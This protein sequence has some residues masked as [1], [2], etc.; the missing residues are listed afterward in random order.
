MTESSRIFRVPG[1]EITESSRIPRVLGAELAEYSRVPWGPGAEMTESSRAPRVLKAEMTESSRVTR[2]PEAQMTGTY[3]FW[4]SDD[5]WSFVSH[6]K[7]SDVSWEQNDDA[8]SHRLETYQYNEK[9]FLNAKTDGIPTIPHATCSSKVE[10]PP[11]LEVATPESKSIH[12]TLSSVC[13]KVHL[14]SDF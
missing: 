13:K 8:Q 6:S 14:T 5:L 12:S 1:V 11:P 10:D 9:H 7:N 3:W 2:V 4:Y